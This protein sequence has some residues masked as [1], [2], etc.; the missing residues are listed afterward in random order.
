MG[1]TVSRIDASI[2]KAKRQNTVLALPSGAARNFPNNLAT[3]TSECPTAF[4][5][6]RRAL[7]PSARMLSGIRR[8][9]A[10]SP[11]I[12]MNLLYMAMLSFSACR[13]CMIMVFK[14]PPTFISDGFV[15]GMPPA[16][17]GQLPT[18]IRSRRIAVY[19]IILILILLLAGTNQHHAAGKTYPVNIKDSKRPKGG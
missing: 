15:V 9:V 18:V 16:K 6:R 13:S 2:E 11:H 14:S 3:P 10:S 1:K 4:P 12:L 19:K 17:T 7:P 8:V 5:G